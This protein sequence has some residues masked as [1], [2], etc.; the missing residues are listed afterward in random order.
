MC[1]S[2][3]SI[4]L[5]K[6]EKGT[7]Q[8][9][10]RRRRTFYPSE[11]NDRIETLGDDELAV[12]AALRI[13]D[14]A[15]GH[16]HYD[17]SRSP[18]D[19]AS[20]DP[21][22]QLRRADY[23]IQAAVAEPKKFDLNLANIWKLKQPKAVHELMR[24][25]AEQIVQRIQAVVP[26]QCEATNSQSVPDGNLKIVEGEALS[27]IVFMVASWAVLSRSIDPNSCAPRLYCDMLGKVLNAAA[28][29]PAFALSLA[30]VVVSLM[31]AEL[32]DRGL[33]VPAVDIVLKHKSSSAACEVKVVAG[34]LLF[35]LDSCR[36]NLA[37]NNLAQPGCYIIGA[38]LAFHLALGLPK[39][40]TA[41]FMECVLY[42]ILVL[43]GWE[44]CTATTVQ[45][46]RQSACYFTERGC[47]QPHTA[48][49]EALVSFACATPFRAR[50]RYA[51]H[52]TAV[53]VS[54]CD[55]SRDGRPCA[56]RE[57]ALFSEAW[58]RYVNGCFVEHLRGCTDGLC[59][60]KADMLCDI[61]SRVLAQFGFEWCWHQWAGKCGGRGAQ[62]EFLRDLLTAAL[63]HT[64]AE[65][66]HALL[67]EAL[68][69]MIPKARASL[70]QCVPS[71]QPSTSAA[72]VKL[73]ELFRTSDPRV[74]EV[75]TALR[76][77]T[78]MIPEL[79]RI[80]ATKDEAAM[81]KQR[82]RFLLDVLLR[83]IYEATELEPFS[84]AV[85][86]LQR[87]APLLKKLQLTRERD[88]SAWVELGLYVCGEAKDGSTC[89]VL[90]SESLECDISLSTFGAFLL[91]AHSQDVAQLDD[92][93]AFFRFLCHQRVLYRRMWARQ[94]LRSALS[95]FGD[96]YISILPSLDTPALSSG[97]SGSFKS[98][99]SGESASRGAQTAL[100]QQKVASLR[101]AMHAFT[102]V[103][104]RSLAEV[105]KAAQQPSNT[106]RGV[107]E[108]LLQELMEL[109]APLAALTPDEL[110]EASASL[111]EPQ[112][113]TGAEIYLAHSRLLLLSSATAS[114]ALEHIIHA[115]R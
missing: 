63:A 88:S 98:S 2:I 67:P 62:S 58:M 6:M 108:E 32:V 75:E 65:R 82:D 51:L 11:G 14:L 43:Y 39:D 56:A 114:A 42:N 111:S 99:G 69:G 18:I 48:V 47:S 34:K 97:S 1:K 20:N 106:D 8:S 4:A 52:A 78:S 53:I 9:T 92:L 95:Q 33:A 96:L 44:S 3:G 87:L 85:H 36:S 54:L 79:I 27:D 22:E 5:L 76:E 80:L 26:K 59:S 40:Q 41:A 30:C 61:T 94:W 84:H 93:V 21:M 35:S 12:C 100:A 77:A 45:R 86:L 38:P 31:P 68:Q 74:I 55:G 107:A 37:R 102:A 91:V 50:P 15:V 109:H 110:R 73:A 57:A 46:L 60:Y 23:A 28:S 49:V 83:S 71:S 19:E 103:V 25:V 72:V 10:E 90:S 104:L 101:S 115:Q 17:G 66:I 24:R 64:Y 113:A 16:P 29:S 13:W 70:F 112:P 89:R 105:S 7:P 81:A